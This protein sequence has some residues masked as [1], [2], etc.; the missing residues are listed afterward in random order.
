MKEN[1]YN[2][3]KMDKKSV[4]TLLRFYIHVK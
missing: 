4:V 2:I 1:L 3:F